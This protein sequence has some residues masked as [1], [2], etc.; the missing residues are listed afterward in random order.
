M[1]RFFGRKLAMPDLLSWMT[2]QMHKLVY[3]EDVLLLNEANRNFDEKS[4]DPKIFCVALPKGTAEVKRFETSRAVIFKSVREGFAAAYDALVLEPSEQGK[5]MERAM[6]IWPD[7]ILDQPPAHILLQRQKE[8]E[9]DRAAQDSVNRDD[10]N[11]SSTSRS[12]SIRNGG[13]ICTDNNG[14][15]TLNVSDESCVENA[16]LNTPMV[17]ELPLSKRQKLARSLTSLHRLITRP[18]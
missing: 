14:N 13:S 3:A 15:Q 10:M 1:V 11:V 18:K 4:Q 6:E 2:N 16:I 7:S 8:R 17:S 9:S 5:G 12:D